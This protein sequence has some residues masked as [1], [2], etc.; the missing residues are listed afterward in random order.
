MLC[1]AVRFTRIVVLLSRPMHIVSRV[2]VHP[3]YHV[4]FT[5]PGNSPGHI[6]ATTTARTVNI[7]SEREFSN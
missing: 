1:L 7:M 6:I 5:V 4:V 2:R 3:G